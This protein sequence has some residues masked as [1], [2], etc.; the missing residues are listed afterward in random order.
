MSTN[1][2][3]PNVEGRDL[4]GDQRHLPIRLFTVCM[5]S[6]IQASGLEELVVNNSFTDL[7]IASSFLNRR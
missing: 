1:Q 4:A 3:V 6:Q 2:I 7:H 5:N